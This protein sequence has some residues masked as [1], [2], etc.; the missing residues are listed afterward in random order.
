MLHAGFLAS[1]APGGSLSDPS[2][3]SAIVAAVTWL[4]H[5][6]LG[7]VATTIAIIAVASIGFM[8]LSGRVNIRHG[9]TVIAGAFILFGA[10]AIVAGLQASLAGAGLAAAPPPPPASEAPPLPPAPPGNPDPYAGASVPNR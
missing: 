6:L 9:L 10:S 1:Y 7:T 5:T 3:S 4:Q 8:M 2:G